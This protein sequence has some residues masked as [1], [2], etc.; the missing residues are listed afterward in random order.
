MYVVIVDAL[1]TG[2]FLASVF[3]QYGYECIHLL[4]STQITQTILKRLNLSDFKISFNVENFPNQA[5]IIDVLSQDPIQ[6]IIPGSES[7]VILADQLAFQLG[8]IKNNIDNLFSRRSKFEMHEVLRSADLLSAQQIRSNDVE[9]IFTWYQKQNFKKVILKPEYSAVSDNV[10]LCKNKNEIARA[11]EQIMTTTNLYG[12]ENTTLVVQEYLCGPEY[13]VNTI[14]VGGKHF[15][16]DIWL[17][18][19]EREEDIS[20]DLYADLVHPSQKNYKELVHY[21]KQVD[22]AT[23]FL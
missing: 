2:I 9:E 4:T 16:T 7:G 17:G 22:K 20:A 1:S 21:V 6:F 19:D 3:K 8:V 10:S 23:L 15:V 14:S 13:I 18:I 5:S 11:F 12:I